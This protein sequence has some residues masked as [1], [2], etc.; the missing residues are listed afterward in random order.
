MQSPEEFNRDLEKR[1]KTCDRHY[2]SRYHK[3]F[4][5]NIDALGQYRR[6]T[7][8]EDAIREA[9][10]K[11]IIYV[12]NQHHVDGEGEIAYRLIKEG[13][14]GKRTV[15]I[16]T[17][18][19]GRDQ[20][21]L[22]AFIEGRMGEREL[23][24][25]LEFTRWGYRWK[26][27][28]SV[29]RA[30]KE[31]G[32]RI[33]ATTDPMKVDLARRDALAAKVVSDYLLKHPDH[34]GFVVHGPEHLAPQALPEKIAALSG[35]RDRLIILTGVEQWYWPMMRHDAKKDGVK[36]NDEVYCF[37]VVSPM[38]ANLTLLAKWDYEDLEE[39]SRSRCAVQES[40][41]FFMK[42]LDV[43]EADIEYP[44]VYSPRSRLAAEALKEASGNNSIGRKIAYY[45]RKGLPVYIPA[46]VK[47]A[48]IKPEDIKS[49][50]AIAAQAISYS[51]VHPPAAKD[52][53]RDGIGR[54]IWQDILEES[55]SS[56][57]AMMV[58]PQ[59]RTPNAGRTDL[60]IKGI[61]D[62]CRDA[63]PETEE[64]Y[65]RCRAAGNSLGERAYDA[66][67]GGSMTRGLMRF[68][69]RQ[70]GKDGGSAYRATAML[71]GLPTH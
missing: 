19:V 52:E 42:A 67:Q 6:E 47:T 18:K 60:S 66:L 38:I 53:T 17:A 23:R 51:G 14:G 25:A 70:G 61:E 54:T 41:R 28:E 10:G 7:D 69:F 31:T 27:V 24:R 43:D 57:G 45:A 37:Y 68:I 50:G 1:L 22:D 64:Y 59:L 62:A 30:A 3:E 16:E 40:I 49:V 65:E 55:V 12:S 58:N 32:A 26:S 36:V 46:D 8:L 21:A 2:R 63:R 5:Q 15:F 9:A 71:A 4:L 39:E 34:T 44:Y 35:E 20:P 11:R 56:L 33:I 29:F 48:I 13:T